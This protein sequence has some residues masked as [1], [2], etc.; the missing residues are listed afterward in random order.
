[1]CQTVT[2]KLAD[3][4]TVGKALE[5]PRDKPEYGRAQIEKKFHDLSAGVLSEAKR[6]G[7]IEVIDRLETLDDITELS[8][9]LY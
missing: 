9:R 1:M 2:L 4:R 5:F 7:L 3:G 8:R 6:A